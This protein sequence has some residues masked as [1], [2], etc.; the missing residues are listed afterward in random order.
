M[1]KLQE[2]EPREEIV[3]VFV[4]PN[5]VDRVHIPVLSEEEEKKRQKRIHD[6]AAKLLRAWLRAQ[7]EKAE[8]GEEPTV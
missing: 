6:A 3:K 8:K 7:A 2:R 1:A 4:R 5:G